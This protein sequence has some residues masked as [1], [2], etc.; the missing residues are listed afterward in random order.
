MQGNTV[1]QIGRGNNLPFGTSAADMTSLSF[2]SFAPTILS[3]GIAEVAAGNTHVCAIVNGGSVI[4]WGSG[5]SGELGNG[6]GGAHIGDGPTEMASI[7]PIAFP[8]SFSSVAVQVTTGKNSSCGKNRSLK[9]QL[10]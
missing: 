2:I 6:N 3:A 10:Y 4:C 9:L 8:A 7:V 5:V 1:G